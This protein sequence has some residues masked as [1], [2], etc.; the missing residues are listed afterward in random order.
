M[1]KQTSRKL[2]RQEDTMRPEYDFSKGVRGKH[3]A[4]Y[5]KGTNVVVLEADVAREFRTTEQVNETLRA[6]SKLLQQYRKRPRRKTA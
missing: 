1:K 5:A 2:A 4:R 3:A 6:V